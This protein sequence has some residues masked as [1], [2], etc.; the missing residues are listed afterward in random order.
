MCDVKILGIVGS[1]RKKGN[2]AK[3]V[4]RALDG[5]KIVS[6]VETEL[7]ELA[8]KKIN[9]CIGCYVCFNTG[10]CF[11]EDDFYDFLRRY[12]WADGV[13]LGATV[14]HMGIHSLMKAAL[15]RLGHGGLSAKSAVQSKDIPKFS[16]VC[17]VLSLGGC[18]CGGQ[19]QV[20]SSLIHSALLM[21]GVVVSGEPEMCDIIGTT[22]YTGTSLECMKSRETIL[23]DKEAMTCAEH[24]GRR[25][26]E[27][28]K[29]VRTGISALEKERPSEYFSGWEEQ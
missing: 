10:T 17:G 20:L 2:T 9:H 18:H 4:Q 15:D 1:P 16:K 29:I 3:L 25:V 8:G 14:Y 5:A 11:Q 26:A 21:N 6:G 22:G 13:I 7:Y 23:K 24:L 12:M 27:M 19:F 28:T